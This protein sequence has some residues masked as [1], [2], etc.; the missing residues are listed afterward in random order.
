VRVGM[1]ERH[2]WAWLRYLQRNRPLLI[3]GMLLMA[4]VLFSASAN[5]CWIPQRRTVVGHAEPGAVLDAP[6]GTDSQ[7]RD[8][9]TVL[10][11]APC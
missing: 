3:G 4:L 11:S 9:L 10:S 5:W 8:L 6:L 1:A 2:G 7:G